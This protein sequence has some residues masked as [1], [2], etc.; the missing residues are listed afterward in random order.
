LR[1]EHVREGEDDG[2]SFASDTP[3]DGDEG[4]RDDDDAGDKHNRHR[5][6]EPEPLGDL[7]D[8]LEEVGPLD[9]LLG[10]APGDVVGE[11]VGEDRLRKRDRQSAEEEEAIVLMEKVSGRIG[12]SAYDKRGNVQEWNPCHVLEE[13]PEKI[14]L[15]QT[16]LQ[17]READ[18][19]RTKED[20]SGREP[21][22][23]TVQIESVHRELESQ[24]DVV[25]DR[26][27][28]RTSDTV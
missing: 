24:E 27:S 12:T 6:R 4:G 5:Q 19:S 21:N 25:K 3:L 22:F 18:V 13:S 14:A 1:R 2:P 11:Q 26:N 23:E 7:R 15:S 28:N 20:N 17:Q 16:V 9:F 8:L 10:R